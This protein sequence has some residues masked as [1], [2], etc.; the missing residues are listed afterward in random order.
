M[1]AKEGKDE[2]VWEAQYAGQVGRY[3]PAPHSA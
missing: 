3:I 1:G 2:N